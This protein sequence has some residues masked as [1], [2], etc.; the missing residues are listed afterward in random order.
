MADS[1]VNRREF[2]RGGAAAAA[3]LTLGTVAAGGAE[4]PL[5]PEAQKTRSYNPAMEYRRLGKTGLMVS[6]VSL[7]GHWKKIPYGYGTPEFKKNRSEVVSACIDHGVNMVDACTGPEILTY[8][9]AL[10]GRRDKM[11]FLFAW[12]VREA[13]VPEWTATVEKMKEGFKLGLKEAGLDYVDVWRLMMHEQTRR[14]NTE[15]EID[16]AMEALNWAKKEGL[17]RFTGISSHDRPWIADAVAKYPQLEVVV[18]PFT[19][20]SKERPTGSIFEALRKHDVGMVGIKPFASGS[21]FKSRGAADSS[22][23]TEDDQRARIVLRYVF[24]CD[25]LAAAIPGM[26]TVDQVKNAAAAVKERREFDVADARKLRQITDDMQA[27]LPPAYQFLND[28][29]WV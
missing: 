12:D 18:T 26:I 17:A 29:E 27:S 14:Q 4:K 19:A 23:K 21:V 10:R 5:T 11:Y 28:W 3:G 16:V 1:Q 2:V 6:V 8:A 25:V 15:K 24:S 9:E 20:A 7:G 13:R 22:T